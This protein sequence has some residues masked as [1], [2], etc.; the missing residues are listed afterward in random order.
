MEGLV[1]YLPLCVGCMFSARIEFGAEEI[2]LPGPKANYWTSGWYRRSYLSH[3]LPE[4]MSNGDLMICIRAIQ[5]QCCYA[6]PYQGPR[7][8]FFV[9]RSRCLCHSPRSGSRRSLASLQYIFRDLHLSS[10]SHQVIFQL[11][12]PP[13][14]PP[15]A[16]TKTTTQPQDDAFI[17]IHPSKMAEFFAFI[18][19]N[20]T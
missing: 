16:M 4:S 15:G 17:Q 14:L 20:L 7:F 18:K 11:N 19:V 1:V 9:S 8:L 2:R 10:L 13:S 12:A 3:R 5:I 6:V